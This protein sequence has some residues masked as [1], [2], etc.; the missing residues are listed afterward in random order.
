M[1]NA[2]HLLIAEDAAHWQCIANGAPPST[3]GLPVEL[4]CGALAR[5]PQLLG[6]PA[7]RAWRQCKDLSSTDWVFP[8]L[9]VGRSCM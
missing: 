7:K 2:K 1:E 4:F 5:V 6:S 9:M 3:G 8:N